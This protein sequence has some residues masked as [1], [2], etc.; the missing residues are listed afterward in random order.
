MADWV[1]LQ[2][3]SGRSPYKRGDL[4][5]A[6]AIED[7]SSPDLLEVR[8]WDELATRSKLFGEHWPLRLDGAFLRRGRRQPLN[9]AYYK[10]LLCLSLGLVE[11]ADRELFELLVA[12]ALTGLTSHP[13]MHVGAPASAGMDPSFRK[14]VKHYTKSSQLIKDEEY[15]RAPLP[16][17]KDLGLDAVSWYPFRDGRS[18]YLH[19]LVQCATGEDWST[20]LSDLHL[21]IW[22]RH[23]NWAVTPVR[24]FSVPFAL[25]MLPERWVRTCTEAGLVLDR[26]R[27]LELDGRHPLTPMLD[28]DVKTRLKYLTQ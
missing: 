26:P 9:L 18:G 13:S 5:S 24:I 20:K 23:I 11:K 22:K 15:H 7:I 25:T 6:I 21:E 12:N 14:R 17:D 19:F 27:L 2:T 3:L 4:K 10:Y 1:E 28:A 16:A 8:V